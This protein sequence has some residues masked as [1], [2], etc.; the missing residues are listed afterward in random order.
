MELTPKKGIVALLDALGTRT[1]TIENAVAFLQSVEKIRAKIGK[2]LEITLQQLKD[3]PELRKML[4]GLRFR[5]FGDT[6]LFTYEIIDEKRFIDYFHRLAF[7][8]NTLMLEAIDLGILFRGAVSI[9]KYIETED[10]ALGPAI[11]DV[12][13][14]YDKIE[15]FGI[16]TTPAGMNYLK[17][18]YS[19][20]YGKSF[21]E[22][23]PVPRIF[24]L[25]AVPI[26][27]DRVLNTYIFDWPSIIFASTQGDAD[28]R[29]RWYYE[30]IRHLNVPK[31]DECK[32]ANTEAFVK[33]SIA[34]QANREKERSAQ[35]HS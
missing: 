25:L 33:E 18:T 4:A 15:L 34:R 27:G 16:I 5:F 21:S 24:R 8:L 10:I 22:S 11:V 29:L 17:A 9:G 13:S 32:Y 23:E 30:R 31:G 14:W 28:E 1:G 3:K 2:N 26:K 35:Q 7:V 12:A 19:N 6:I 20:Q